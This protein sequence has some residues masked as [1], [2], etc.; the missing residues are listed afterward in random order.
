M[1]QAGVI[2]DFMVALGFKTDNSGLE[3]MQG[4]MEGVELKATALKGALMALATGAVIAVRQ[5]A[6][7]LDKLYFSSQRIGASV[8]NINAYGNAI[9]QLGGSAEE[10]VG[11]LE[12]LAE[13]MR[14]SPGYE[15]QIKSLGVDTR[16]ANGE[17]RDRVEMMKDLSGV[18]AKMPAYQANAYASSLGIDQ[19]TLLAM[20]DGKFMANMEKY[21]KIQKELGMSDELAKSGNEFMTEYRDLTMMTK[22]GFQVIVMQAGKA[23]IPV[24]RLLNQL[25]QAGIHAFSQLNPQIKEGL[26]VALRFGMLAIIF[27]AFF[28]T[29]GVLLKIIPLLKIFIG[30]LKMMRLAFLASPIGIILALAS[31]LALLYDD[32][33]TWRDGGKSLFDWSKWTNG[34][35]TIIN[36]I[37][38]FLKMLDEIKDKVINFVQ[39]V[40]SDPVEAVKEVAEIAADEA[41]NLAQKGADALN[42]KIA[43]TDTGKKI[44]DKVGEGTAKVSA[45]FG[46]EEAQNAVKANEGKP[47][48][49]LSDITK[50]GVDVLVGTAKV[51]QSEVKKTV[52]SDTKYAFSF[53]KDV[54]QYIKEASVK[55][56]IDEQ[57]LRGF[58]KMEAGWTGKMSPTGAIGTGQFIQSTWN[59]LAKT[60][61]G[62]EIGMTK[63]DKSNFRKANDPRRNKHVNTLA[64]GLLAQQNSEVLK[65]YGIPITGENLYLAHNIG[66]ATF[67][68]AL[69]GRANADG[70]KAMRQNGMKESE[71]PRQFVD[72]QR[73]I[74]M[75]HYKIANKTKDLSLVT[76]TNSRELAKFAQNA[77]VP[78]GNPHKA[79]VNSSNMQSRSI[80]IH[81]SYKTDMSISGVE[82]PVEIANTV[83]KQQENSMVF[84]ARSA[85]GVLG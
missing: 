11:T 69:T 80:V 54:D 10:A 32:Y 3:K 84:M 50:K 58:V 14:N 41:K 34:I 16:D 29:F 20:R 65:K 82:S 60:D 42:D 53:G 21:Q 61:A 7:E 44:L 27:G 49:T 23:L 74:Y 8:S 83:K 62:K 1:A 37:K 18:L 13:K 38:D 79:Q 47:A 64:T 75:K 76:P 6:S 81:Q 46:N 35:D 70:L 24:L 57:V 72:R 31:A 15:S 68:K 77:E 17:M 25:I 26:A 4:A 22:T 19:N 5:T 56:G 59:G 71:T 12:S 55:Y 39:K 51:V 33:K 66:A 78:K 85:Q 9:T 45:F 2:R 43:E 40:I 30:L 28:K 73:A 63:I 36:K 52:G 67:A 48:T